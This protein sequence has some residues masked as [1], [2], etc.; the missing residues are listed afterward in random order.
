LVEVY[1]HQEGLKLER[2]LHHK[3]H[4]TTPLLGDDFIDLAEVFAPD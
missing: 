3:D 1:R 4:L 2:T